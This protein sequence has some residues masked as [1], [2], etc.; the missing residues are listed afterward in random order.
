L[1]NIVAG[2]KCFSRIAYIIEKAF[3]QEKYTFLQ[4]KVLASKHRGRDTKEQ[5]VVRTLEHFL[6]SYSHAPTDE[7]LVKT[8]S[9]V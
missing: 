7:L 2:T 8:A 3:F 6:K 4:K 5:R 9:A 1:F